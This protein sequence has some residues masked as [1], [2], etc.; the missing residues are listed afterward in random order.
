[1]V[2]Q[3]QLILVI[4]RKL[5]KTKMESLSKNHRCSQMYGCL[6]KENGNALVVTLQIYQ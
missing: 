2:E 6:K 4:K 1:M 5:E 3:L